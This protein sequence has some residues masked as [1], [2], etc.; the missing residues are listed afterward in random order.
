MIIG[1]RADDSYFTFAQDFIAG[2]ISLSKLSEA[3]HLGKPGEQVVL[4]SKKAFS[5]IRF[6]DAEPADALTY[7]EKKTNR[8]LQARR[9]YRNVKSSKDSL[10]ELFIL[11]IMR[12]GIK[13]G[14]PRLQ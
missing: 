11:D 13:N 9:A 6:R 1:Y 4:K 7:Y 5:Q 2:T 14:D 12:E 3:M 10:S 8:D